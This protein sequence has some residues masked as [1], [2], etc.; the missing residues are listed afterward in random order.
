MTRLKE[1]LSF[2]NIYLPLPFLPALRKRKP[3][4]G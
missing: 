4:S 2:V 3:G 1:E